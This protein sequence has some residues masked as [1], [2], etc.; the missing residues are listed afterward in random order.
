MADGKDGLWHRLYHGETTFRFVPL[1]RRW[2]VISGL[3]IVIGILSLVTRGLNLGIDFEGGTSWEVD[4]GD[5]SVDDV[6]DELRGLGLGDAKIQTIGGDLIRVQADIGEGEGAADKRREVTAALEEV[7]GSDDVSVNNVGPSWG[8]D[9]TRKAQRALVFFLVAIAL[10][11]SLRFEW[12]MALAALSAVVH[13][14]LVTLGVYSLSGFEVTPATVVA[15]LTIL[16]FS[17]YDTIVVFDKVEENTKGLAATGRMT[18]SDVVDLSMN[19]VLMRSLNTSFV[20]VLPIA[21]VLFVGAYGMG[22]TALRDFGLALMVGLTTGAYSSLYIASPVLALL[23]ERE[24]RYATI[25]QRLQTRGAAAGGPLSP[26]AAA[27]LTASGEGEEAGDGDGETRPAGTGPLRPRAAS[28]TATVERPGY[29]T[30][31][32]QPPRGRKKQRR[33]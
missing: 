21:S 16:G 3:V 2:L 28:G 4:R 17:L 9:V 6:R 26:A 20:A 30:G 19:Q 13:D 33:R 18:Y 15:F 12:K 27:T 14:V 10:Y 29:V 23:K 11:I 5:A 24:P 8:K 1:W 32:G 22:A 25:R 7:T 31:T